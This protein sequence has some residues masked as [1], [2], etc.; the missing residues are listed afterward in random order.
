MPIRT[1]SELRQRARQLG[2]KRVAV[3]MA[4]DEV[5]LTAAHDAMRLGIATPVLIGDEPRIRALA[6]ATGLDDLLG[7]AEF[8]ATDAP[9]VAGAHL[10]GSGRVDII[11][12]GHLRTDE[13]LR[14][15]LDKEAGLRTGNLLSDILLYED[16]LSGAT[17]LVGITD[18]GLNVAPNLDQKKQ[19][20]QNAIAVLHCLG[21][22]KPKIAVM[23]ASDAISQGMPSTTDA[24]ALTEMGRQGVFGE[25]E[26]YGPLALDNALLMSAAEAKGIRNPVAG[27]ADCMVAP[28]IEAG[29]LLGKA[30]KYFAGSQCAHVV[31]GAKVPILIP[32]RVE[33]ADDKVNAIALGV[34]YA[35]R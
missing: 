23:S 9:A 34:L 21:V 17:R 13:L 2:P 35:G 31:V 33:S 27:R 18:G 11:L 3:V 4:D 20:V 7:Q 28:S 25:A 16:T 15:L 1:F 22:A 10:A 24:A 32:S 26:V 29:N 19:I 12:K 5:A 8:V 14:A 6:A 30:V